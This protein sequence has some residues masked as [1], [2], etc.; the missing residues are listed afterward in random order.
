[1]KNMIH[2]ALKTG[3]SFREVYGHLD[4]T[5]EYKNENIIGCA[6]LSNTFV[7]YYLEKESNKDEDL[8]VIFG[9]RLNVVKNGSE[10]VKPRGQFGPQ[11]IFLAKNEIGLKEIYGLVKINYDNF[12]YRGQI[13]FSDVLNLSENVIVIAE[14][15]QCTDRLDYIALTTTTPNYMVEEGLEFDIPF[16]SIINN[17]YP[18]EK[19][20]GVYELLVGPRNMQSQTYPQWIMS[21]DEYACF[22]AEKGRSVELIESAIENTYVIADSIS[23]FKLPKAPMIKTNIKSSVSYLCKIGAKNKNI[24]LKDGEYSERYNYE[25]ELIEKRGYQDYFLVVADMISK[26]KKKMLVG[27]G[28]GSSGGSLVC[29]LMGITEVD[30]IKHGL[31]FERFIDITRTDLPDIDIDFPDSSREKVIKKVISDYGE[32]KVKSI[33]NVSKLQGRSAIGNF[34]KYLKIPIAET[35]AMKDSLIERFSGHPRAHKCV[36]DSFE[37]LEIGKSYLE[38]YPNM[39]YA[40]EIEDHPDHSSV[41]A[42]GVIVCNDPIHYYGGVN[43]RDNTVMLDK[44][45]SEYQNLLKIDVLGLRTL[46]VLEETAKLCGMKHT[47]L[48]TLPLDD[49]KTFDILTEVRVD[50]VF[51]FEGGALK[52]LTSQMGITKF[53]DIVAVTAL[54]RPGALHSGG[55]ARYV[56]C[57]LGQEKPIYVGESHKEITED[58]Y[59]IIVFQEQIMLLCSEIGNLSHSD[60]NA[61][62]KAFSKSLGDEY[63]SKYK[64]DFINGAKQNGYTEDDAQFLWSE[65]SHSGSYAFNKSHSVAY[66]LVSYWTAYMKANHP[67]EFV[68]GAL[69]NSKDDESAVRILRDAV[70]KDGVEYDPL[71]PEKSLLYWSVNDGK[72]IGGLTS[73]KG[74]GVQKART[75]IKA[76]TGEAELTPSLYKALINPKTPFDDLTPC[77][78]YFREIYEDPFKHGLSAA[79]SYCRDV[80]GKGMHVFIGRLVSKT[81]K[82]LNEHAAIE[83]RNGTVFEDNAL[84]LALKFEDD[85]DL[86]MCSIGRF[87]Y[88]DLAEDIVENGIVDEDYYM[89][90]GEIWREGSR[91]LSVKNIMKLNI[92]DYGHEEENFYAELRD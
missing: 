50:G 75:I 72:I 89:V 39:K 54:A 66:G 8:K 55:A 67:L 15:V 84:E 3:Y 58:T 70:Q 44:K 78:T 79:P 12:Y 86:L 9:V 92:Y 88:D 4:K 29:Y 61:V 90:M 16:V 60:V 42:A 24:N 21:T 38:K 20:R 31:M 28:R 69:N 59:G 62:R 23:K 81:V 74:I 41:H 36:E 77:Y 71:D 68:V 6:D 27:P 45:G 10:K 80:N 18:E 30:P 51:Q 57:R 11:Y 63:F 22:Q 47:D 33:A 82:D 19:D 17:F 48:Y 87:D 13:S 7:H 14:D 35:E 40:A 65:I 49:Q 52:G 37:T 2:L 53:E 76:R 26:A 56:K 43:A 83:K 91:Y 46:A 1:M 32:L 85:T 25:M 73:I 64:D 5:L 34:A